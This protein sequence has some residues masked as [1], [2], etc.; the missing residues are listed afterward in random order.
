MWEHRHSSDFQFRW[1]LDFRM[2]SLNFE[3]LVDLVRQRSEKHDTQLRT[4]IPI[5]RRAAVA[6]WRLS[7][8]NSFHTVSKTFAIG[9]S[10]AV[11]ITRDVCAEIFRLSLQFIKFPI[12][13]LETAKNY[14]KL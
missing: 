5:E 3:K 10:T 14:R 13:Q 8:G 7:T 4:A 6:L 9:K 2:N 12:S 11:T 1:K